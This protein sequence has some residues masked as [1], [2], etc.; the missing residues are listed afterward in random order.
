MTST[1]LS[2]SGSV[3]ASSIRSARPSGLTVKVEA[4]SASRLSVGCQSSGAVVPA[5]LA[6][7]PDVRTATPLASAVAETPP[8]PEVGQATG[9]GERE[10]L[11]EARLVPR[12]DQHLVVRDVGGDAARDAAPQ[13]DL[14]RRPPP[15]RPRRP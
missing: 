6:S 12:N 2:G 1:A 3:R 11:L 7:S 10:A 4:R 13:H 9:A 14:P 5:H 15:P 8:G